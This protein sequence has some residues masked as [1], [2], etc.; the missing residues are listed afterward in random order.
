ML[1]T[2]VLPDEK[3]SSVKWR[4]RWQIAMPVTRPVLFNTPT[5]I[6]ELY[7]SQTT[8]AQPSNPHAQG[9]K[10]SAPK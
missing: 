1:K 4:T 5:K 8:H 6:Y 10:L 7:S 2:F 9:I 3:I